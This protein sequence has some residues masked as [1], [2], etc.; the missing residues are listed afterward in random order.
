MPPRRKERSGL[1]PLWG[2]GETQD[3]LEGLCLPVGLGT[4]WG[5]AGIAGGGEYVQGS[6]APQADLG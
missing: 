5:P 3:T 6:L 1:V 4:P 2:L